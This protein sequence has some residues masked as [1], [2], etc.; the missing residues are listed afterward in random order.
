MLIHVVPISILI[1]SNLLLQFEKKCL[2]SYN[3]LSFKIVNKASSKFDLK[4]KGGLCINPIQNGR[5]P[6]CSM[7]WGGGGGGGKK[8]PSPWNLSHI[9]YK[10]ETWHSYILPKEDP[11]NRWIT[12]YTLWVLLTQHFSSE[13][14]KSC[15]IRK[16]KYRLY[17]DT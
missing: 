4:I 12:W 3:T 6:G 14:S 15:Y 13:I 17:F 2:Y 10:D 1:A 7:T 5:F 8:A 16:Y 11:E 9:S